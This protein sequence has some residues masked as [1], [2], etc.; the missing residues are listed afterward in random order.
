MKNK[1][2]Y[3]IYDAT[4]CM[5]NGDPDT[6]EQ[7]YDEIEKK[8]IVSDLR[9]KRF[10]RDYLNNFSDSENNNVFYFYDRSDIDADKDSSGSA[11]RFDSFCKK[12]K[13]ALD[14][15]TNTEE[16]LLKYFSDVRVFGG[17]LTHKK[18]PKAQITGALQFNAENKSIN[19]IN[20]SENLINRGITTVFPSKGEKNSG[21]MGRDSFIKYGLFSI[22]GRFNANVAKYNYT[23]EN[24]FN[25]MLSSIW[26]GMKTINTRSKIG[27]NP[28]AFIIIN[29]PT[30]EL[31]NGNLVGDV[32]KYSF[33]PFSIESNKKSSRINSMVDYE[34]NFNNLYQIMDDS[35]LVEGVDV[36][37]DDNEFIKKYFNDHKFNIINPFNDVIMKMIS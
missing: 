28:I 1:S 11:N 30:I 24:D 29:H 33:S 21:S 2:L 16:I 17:I 25:N 14:K 32:L 8:A 36:F 12:K 23:N 7:R 37:C 9:I 6:G 19:E 10:G 31:K 34:F 22:I 15:N 26:M 20:Y 13:I 35:K 4:N 27:H 5:P 18:S 3:L